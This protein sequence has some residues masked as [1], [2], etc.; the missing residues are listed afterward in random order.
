MT[1]DIVAGVTTQPCDY[2]GPCVPPTLPPVDENPLPTTTV[3]A[4]LITDSEPLPM[5]GAALTG[6]VFAAVALLIVGGLLT[7]EGRRRRRQRAAQGA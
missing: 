2:A 7:G 4:T 1:S 6:A 3:P 5:T